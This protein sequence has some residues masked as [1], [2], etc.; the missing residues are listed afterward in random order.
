MI[1]KTL[2]LLGIVLLVGIIGAVAFSIRN[3]DFT[4]EV[5]K[6]SIDKLCKAEKIKL[7]DYKTKVC[8]DKDKDKFDIG[9]DQS[10]ISIMKNPDTGVIRVAVNPPAK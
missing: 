10:I 1:K 6:I 5:K 3:E 8:K 7:E 2:I 4:E 9:I